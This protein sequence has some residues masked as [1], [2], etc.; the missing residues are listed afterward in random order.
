MLLA[1]NV[2]LAI[3]AH[4]HV[5]IRVT[6]RMLLWTIIGQRCHRHLVSLEV[7]GVGLSWR[8]RTACH[9][10]SIYLCSAVGRYP[11]RPSRRKTTTPQ[12]SR[13]TKR[14]LATFFAPVPWLHSPR[15]CIRVYVVI[16]RS[17][18]TQFSELPRPSR[19]IFIR[20]RASQTLMQCIR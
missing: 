10:G 16:R 17:H 19:L 3:L 18:Q 11:P 13:T 7:F 8:C 15:L 20:S 9:S 6:Q 2:A 5:I 1:Y 4:G 14:G 12:L